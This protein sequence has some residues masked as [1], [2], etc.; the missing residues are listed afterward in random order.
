MDYARRVGLQNQTECLLEMRIKLLIVVSNLL[1][2]P[3]IFVLCRGFL[4]ERDAFSR[5]CP[6]ELAVA[7]KHVVCTPSNQ[8][9]SVPTTITKMTAEDDI[10]AY[11][12]ISCSLFLRPELAKKISHVRTSARLNS[13]SQTASFLILAT[14]LRKARR[15]GII[16]NRPKI[17]I[18]RDQ[19]LRHETQLTRLEDLTGLKRDR[20]TEIVTPLQE[21]KNK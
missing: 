6:I 14:F 7:E 5:Y 8:S 17:W 3:A 10:T 16:A 18:T 2:V 15:T 4:A 12:A 13:V 19:S 11:S 9:W 21:L 1:G 20:C